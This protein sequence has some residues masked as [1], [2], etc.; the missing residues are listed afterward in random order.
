M[1]RRDGHG[2][3][4]ECGYGTDMEQ[5]M[6]V[7]MARIWDYARMCTRHG[8]GI[9][10]ECVHGKDMEQGTDVCG[11]AYKHLHCT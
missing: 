10:H 4:H 1:W 8:Y 9:T 3:W 6:N 11:Q 2:T 7:D 5:C